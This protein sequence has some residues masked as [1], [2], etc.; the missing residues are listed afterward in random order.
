MGFCAQRS[1][2]AV[3]GSKESRFQILLAFPPEGS[4]CRLKSTER[5]CPA[6]PGLLK[7][8]QC[9]F[10]RVALSVWHQVL[11]EPRQFCISTDCCHQQILFYGV[12]KVKMR[13]FCVFV[14]LLSPPR[15][16]ALLPSP[17]HCVGKWHRGHQLG[18]S[19]GPSGS[20]EFPAA[21]SWELQPPA[22]PGRQVALTPG[23]CH[24]QSPVVPS[25]L[26]LLTRIDLWYPLVLLAPVHAHGVQVCS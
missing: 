8:S 2:A 10:Q 12:I 3:L 23:P 15:A 20:M 22:C 9:S 18:I 6:F 19:T 16:A 13:G 5:A 26:L 24:V 17:S 14:L 11:Q 4:G 1:L 7:A 25:L 21:A